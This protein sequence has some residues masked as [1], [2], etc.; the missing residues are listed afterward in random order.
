MSDLSILSDRFIADFRAGTNHPIC[1]V[2]IVYGDTLGGFFNILFVK[3]V[4]CPFSKG[5]KLIN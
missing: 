4:D 3:S 2:T 5:I 1:G